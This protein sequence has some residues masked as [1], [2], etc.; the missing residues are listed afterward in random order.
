MNSS[1]ERTPGDI[2]PEL[3]AA[4]AYHEAGHAVAY[5]LAYRNVHLPP[6]NPPPSVKHVS[7]VRQEDG[8]FGGLCFGSNVYR[9][10]YAANLPQWPW[11]HAMEWQIMMNMAGGV[12]EAIHRGERRQRHVM[13]FALFDCGTESDLEN[14]E[15]VLAD[16]RELTGSRYDLQRFV[17]Q[18]LKL[19]LEH[20]PA[21]DALALRLIEA[22]R[23]EGDEL[24]RI[25][26]EAGQ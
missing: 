9:P 15:K 18:T 20:W 4:I 26:T 16:L 25:V 23:V 14:A 7:I 24:L 2:A 17:V 21:V 12:A 6:L 11:Q 5:V 10:E 19:L 22:R 13:W 3:L 8:K 1:D